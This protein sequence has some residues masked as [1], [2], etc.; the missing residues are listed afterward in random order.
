MVVRFLDVGELEDVSYGLQLFLPQ[1]EICEEKMAGTNF[2]F[3]CGGVM[4]IWLAGL[5]VS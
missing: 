1:V 4:D 5:I 3:L 2:S